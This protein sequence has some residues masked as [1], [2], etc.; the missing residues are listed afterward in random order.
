MVVIPEA[1]PSSVHGE[2]GSVK[3][4]VRV[5]YDRPWAFDDEFIESFTVVCPINLNL[6]PSLRNPA[7]DSVT[8]DI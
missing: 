8:D 6:D 5:K 3:Y 1:A 7:E 4:D 2:Y